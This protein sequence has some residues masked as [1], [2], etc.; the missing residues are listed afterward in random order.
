MVP[1]GFKVFGTVFGMAANPSFGGL[2]WP[3][4]VEGTELVVLG[5]LLFQAGVEAVVAGVVEGIGVER[6]GPLIAGFVNVADGVF[7]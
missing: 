5:V 7:G 3:Y 4:A 2:G 6:I 1:N